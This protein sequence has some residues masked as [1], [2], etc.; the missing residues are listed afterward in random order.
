MKLQF[1][2]LFM[3][4]FNVMFKGKTFFKFKIRIGTVEMGLLRESKNGE[5]VLKILFGWYNY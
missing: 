3:G 1:F 4:F 2:K 5:S